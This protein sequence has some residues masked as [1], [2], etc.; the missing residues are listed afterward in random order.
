LTV[1]VE[2]HFFCVDSISLVENLLST[3]DFRIVKD[4]FSSLFLKIAVD[5]KDVE[6]TSTKLELFTKTVE[7]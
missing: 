6:I 2:K 5:L 1:Y 3:V 4:E 7:D